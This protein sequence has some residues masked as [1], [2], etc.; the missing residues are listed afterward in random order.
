MTRKGQKKLGKIERKRVKTKS[1]DEEA[2][3]LYTY[4]IYI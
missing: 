4:I 2:E 1:K 3:I